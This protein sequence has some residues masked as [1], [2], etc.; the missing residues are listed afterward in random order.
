MSFSISQKNDP[1]FL[2]GSKTEMAVEDVF[3]PGSK[4]REGTKLEE[5]ENFLRE[6]LARGE[7]VVADLKKSASDLGISWR[8]VWRAK[9]SLHIKASKDGFEGGWQ[10]RLPA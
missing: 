4:K 6:E 3:T 9:D 2:W 7:R 5:A 8:T 1:V 10:W